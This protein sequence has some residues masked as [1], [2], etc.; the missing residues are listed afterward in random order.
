VVWQSVVNGQKLKFRLAGINNQNFIMRDE[1]TGSWWQQ[2]SGE[3]IQGSFKGQKLTSVETDELSFGVW[4]RE[5]PNGIVLRPDPKILAEG[6]YEGADWET[7]VGKMPVN[8]SAKVNKV[9]EP[10]ALVVGVSINGKAKAYPFSSIVKQAPI[11]DTVGGKD[12]VVVLG[13]DKKSVRAFERD[14]NGRK[15]E[16]LMKP[17]SNELIDAETGSTW[18]FS[19]KAI[20]GELTGSQLNRVTALKDYWFDWQTYNPETQL[21]SLEFVF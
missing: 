18:D 2:I 5:N 13:D 1:E 9:L 19:G 14:L 17:E 15:L 16:F 12:I 6:K 21:Y 4:K 10:R 7:Q 20:K 11:L 3:A 8:I